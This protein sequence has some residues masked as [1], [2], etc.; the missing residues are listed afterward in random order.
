M[1]L[2]VIQVVFHKYF[3]PENPFLELPKMETHDY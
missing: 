2:T 3:I 1:A